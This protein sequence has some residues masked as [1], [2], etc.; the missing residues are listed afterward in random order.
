M[1]AQETPQPRAQ[2]GQFGRRKDVS[3]PRRDKRHTANQAE[4]ANRRV[5]EAQQRLAEETQKTVRTANYAAGLRKKVQ[6]LSKAAP[7]LL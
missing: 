7:P 2:G 1:Q 6:Q 5:V 3:I 4:M